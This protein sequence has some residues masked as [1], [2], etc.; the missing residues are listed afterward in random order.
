MEQAQL[1]FNSSQYIKALECLD[2]TIESNS[3]RLGEA[4]FLKGRCLLRL[5]RKDD[6]IEF[7]DK[8]IQ[9][10]H[11]GALN[12]KGLLLRNQ[13]ESGF[14][15]KKALELNE[16]PINEEDFK[17][18]GLSLNGLDKYE[19]AVSCFDEAIQINSND[20]NTFKIKGDCLFDMTKYEEAIECY[21]KAI[22][23]NPNCE[24]AFINKGNC[25]HNIGKYADALDCYNRAID[26]NPNYENTLKLKQKSLE[27]LAKTWRKR[28]H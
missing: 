5:S 23:M 21:N 14:L 6:A 22:F 10:N 27:K 9:F 18:K 13:L 8:A 26:L 25:L 28:L 4:Y 7:Y 1:L 20:S 2:K 15:F 19:D 12:F 3:D 11:V 17:N 24:I 16:I